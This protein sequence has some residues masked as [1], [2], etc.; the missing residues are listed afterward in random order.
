MLLCG[1]NFTKFCSTSNPS[2]NSRL[3]IVL[4]I[5]GRDEPWLFNIKIIAQFLLP[6]HRFQQ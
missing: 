2:K 1:P 5:C 6:S 4:G 3:V